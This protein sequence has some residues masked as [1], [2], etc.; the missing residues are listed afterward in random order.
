MVGNYGPAAGVAEIS[1]RH[2][3]KSLRCFFHAARSNLL[4]AAGNSIISPHPSLGPVSG[5][6]N[7]GWRGPLCGFVFR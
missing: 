6:V 7:S 4:R 5:F 1:R 3:G 2:C